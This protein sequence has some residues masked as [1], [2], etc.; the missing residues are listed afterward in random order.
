MESV[1]A[2]LEKNALDC[3]ALAARITPAACAS[4]RA[5][6]RP[7]HCKEWI[8]PRQCQGCA[9]L[10]AQAPPL[11]ARVRQIPPI[12]ERRAKAKP[13]SGPKVTRPRGGQR[14]KR[15]P[16]VRSTLIADLERLAKAGHAA[17]GRLLE[18]LK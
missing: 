18:Q 5:G 9:G 14:E 17:S 10:E 1:G 11:P 4:Y 7:L 16:V 13:A 8:V 3:R 2:W 12:E 6:R 15:P